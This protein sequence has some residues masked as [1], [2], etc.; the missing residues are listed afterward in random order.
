MRIIRSTVGRLLFGV[1]VFILD[2]E[3]SLILTNIKS[4]WWLLSRF[5]L[6]APSFDNHILHSGSGRFLDILLTLIHSLFCAG[7]YH[8][9]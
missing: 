3:I 1:D 8:Y 4:L 6:P 9:I 7:R 5:L 2:G